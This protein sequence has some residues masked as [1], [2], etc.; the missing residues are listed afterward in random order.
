MASPFGSPG[1]AGLAGHPARGAGVIGAAPGY[2]PSRVQLHPVGG[3][4]PSLF[5]PVFTLPHGSLFALFREV[6]PLPRL[7]VLRHLRCAALRDE[8]LRG[9]ALAACTCR[10]SSLS[11]CVRLG[12]SKNVTRGFFLLTC[13]ASVGSR[14]FLLVLYSFVVQF[15]RDYKTSLGEYIA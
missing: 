5:C 10:S 7:L 4:K 9:H 2:S 14:D 15:A 6:T 13:D 1:P 12:S 11:L 3:K 8:P